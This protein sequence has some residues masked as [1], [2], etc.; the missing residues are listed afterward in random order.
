MSI[1]L[2]LAQIGLAL[3]V[4]LLYVLWLRLPDASVL[5]VIGS[6]VL[7]LII[8]A[9]AG[10][11]ES[12]LILRVAGRACTPG[13]LLRG[14][15]LLL[16]GV[17][18]WFAWSALLNHLHGDDYLRAG[19]WNS[20]FPHRLR[21]LFSFEHILLWLGWTWTALAWIG[22]SVIGLFVF[23]GTASA[24]PL[25]TML[26]LLRC[27]TYW[28]FAVFAAITAT[29][30][31]GSLLN[32]TPGHGLRVEMMSLMFRLSLAALVD[33]ILVC[34]LLAIMAAC[35]RQSDALYAAPAGTPDESQPRTA[36]NP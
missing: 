33:A 16:A 18:L 22:G 15:F 19:Y 27:F 20:R 3:L 24:R 30:L 35:T 7:A 9:V 1:R 14:S 11:G 10:A 34:F 6:A 26:R 28:I 21:N 13:K 12:A 29:V 25:R 32:W 23:A 31:V 5:D 17:A 2:V 36:D 8:L 4:V